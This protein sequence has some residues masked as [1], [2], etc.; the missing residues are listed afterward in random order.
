MLLSRH[1]VGTYLEM[2]SNAI[3][4][5]A[6]L[7]WTD[8]GIMSGIS[9]RELISTS[10]NKNKTQKAPVENEWSNILPKSLQARKEPPP[11][12]GTSSVQCL[13]VHITER[14]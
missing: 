7:L 13:P 10:K 5:L 3:C 11:P 4:Q 14:S 8:P 6:E 1:S 2:S 12:L 9:V